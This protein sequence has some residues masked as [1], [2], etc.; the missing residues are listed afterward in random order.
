MPLIR[1]KRFFRTLDYNINKV[2]SY[3]FSY[4]KVDGIYIKKII[5]CILPDAA[6]YFTTFEASDS[7]AL[8]VKKV[9]LRNY[10]FKGKFDLY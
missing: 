8:S 5:K 4:G 7:K 6:W 3:G 2:Y 9:K 10:G 1:S